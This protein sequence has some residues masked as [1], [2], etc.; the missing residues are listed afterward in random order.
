M[1][2]MINPLIATSGTLINMATVATGTVLGR[3]IGRRLPTRFQDTILQ[4]LGL[5]TI[6]LGVLNG[7]QTRN[8]LYVLAGILFGCVLGEALDV[9]GALARLGAA[10]QRRFAAEGSRLSEAFVTSSLV[11]CVGPL[12]ILG[13]IQ[14]GISGDNQSLVFKATLDGFASFAFSAALGWGVILSVATI[15]IFQGA[16]SLG[17]GLISPIVDAPMIAEMSATGGLI[18]IAIGL[19]LLKIAELR[20]GN[21]LPSLLVA[22][23]A[24]KLIE[25]LHPCIGSSCAR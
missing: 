13:A 2:R 4:G 18:I 11:F 23:G 9:D 5:A 6:L 7:Q 1:P 12:T 21:F 25:A 8:P 15:G 19:R 3:L 16:L 24:V 22:P 10:L 17:A 14:N 20:I